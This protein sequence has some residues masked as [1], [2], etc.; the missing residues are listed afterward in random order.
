[1]GENRRAIEI[2][3]EKLKKELSLEKPNK[4]KIKRLRESIKRHKE[5][6]KSIRKTKYMKKH[7]ARI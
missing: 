6:D 3:K 7:K 1:M 5:I 4:C 2:K